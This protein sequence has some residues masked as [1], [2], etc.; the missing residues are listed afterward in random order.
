MLTDVRH[1]GNKESKLK[2]AGAPYQEEYRVE[3]PMKS[4]YYNKSI[5]EKELSYVIKVV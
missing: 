1:E 5:T 3:I 4:D 2:K